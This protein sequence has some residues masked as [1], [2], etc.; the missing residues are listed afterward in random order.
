MIT[1]FEYPNEDVFTIDGTINGTINGTI[2]GPIHRKD[3]DTDDDDVFELLFF[4]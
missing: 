1:I 2:D 3:S 4:P